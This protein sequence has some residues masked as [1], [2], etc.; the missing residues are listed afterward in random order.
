VITVE[1]AAAEQEGQDRVRPRRLVQLVVVLGLQMAAATVA[2][3]PTDP[4][5]CRLDQ[6]PW[7]PCVLQLDAD[8]LGWRLTIVTQQSLQ[9]KHDG[10]GR[11]SMRRGSAPWQAVEARWLA[12]AS[13][14]WNGVCARGPIPLD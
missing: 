12:D 1:A 2:A 9:F 7:L 8:G 5:T 11:V 3:G 14:C 4:L 10:F 6:G 13:L